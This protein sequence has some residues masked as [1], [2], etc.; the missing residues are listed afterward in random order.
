M[1]WTAESNY[2][3]EQAVRQKIA[4]GSTLNNAFKEVGESE[5]FN[6]SLRAISNQ[7]Y[8]LHANSE[9]NKPDDLDLA[10][11]VSALMEAGIELEAAI[12]E[13]AYRM[14]RF[15]STCMERW[16]TLT[17]GTSDEVMVPS[18][19]KPVAIAPS[20]PF[21]NV[22]GQFKDLHSDYQR[23]LGENERLFEENQTLKSVLEKISLLIQDAK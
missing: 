11:G 17:M 22:L 3:M 6:L 8:R 5:E 7:W 20:D 16:R 19:P 12:K 10:T 13:M 2:L 14:S 15:P 18:T 1:N 9:W 4:S 23:V 21:E